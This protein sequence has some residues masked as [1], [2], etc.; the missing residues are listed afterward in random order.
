MIYVLIAEFA[1]NIC[2]V[3][4]LYE[5]S[6]HPWFVRPS[7]SFV[8]ISW[9]SWPVSVTFIIFEIGGFG[10]ITKEASDSCMH[11]S[12]SFYLLQDQFHSFSWARQKFSLIGQNPNCVSSW[13]DPK[14][15]IVFFWRL[16]MIQCELQIKGLCSGKWFRYLQP[17]NLHDRE[18]S[19]FTLVIFFQLYFL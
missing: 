12:L 16:I 1:G 3:L 18:M 2:F 7:V 5:S 10:A 8:S 4:A 15:R 6:Y 9:A 14:A 11:H 13:F 19:K 17:Q